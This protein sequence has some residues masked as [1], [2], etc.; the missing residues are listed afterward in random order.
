MVT[1]SKDLRTGQ[2][3]WPTDLA[4]GYPVAA[5]TKLGKDADASAMAV[6]QR[7][8]VQLAD[9]ISKLF[10]KWKPEDMRPDNFSE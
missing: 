2:T 10:Y 3:L 4:D 9:D 1:K 8:Y 6:R 7:L 5:S